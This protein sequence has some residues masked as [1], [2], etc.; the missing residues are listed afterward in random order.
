VQSPEIIAHEIRNIDV[1]SLRDQIGVPTASDAPN[2]YDDI[3]E[4]KK[5]MAAPLANKDPNAP[6][7]NKPEP[8][9]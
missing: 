4:S 7:P 1:Q 8:P 2:D 6:T 5:E 9:K 3:L